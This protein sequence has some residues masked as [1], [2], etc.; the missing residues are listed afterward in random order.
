MWYICVY[1]DLYMYS[2]LYQILKYS[3]W[4]EW[5]VKLSSAYFIQKAHQKR[6]F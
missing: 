2:V 4:Y 1:I 5:N 6:I 3:S